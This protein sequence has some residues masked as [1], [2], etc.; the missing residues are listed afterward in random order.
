MRYAVKLDSTDGKYLS[1]SYSDDGVDCYSWDDGVECATLMSLK[2]ASRI[3]IAVNQLSFSTEIVAV[4]QVT[5][6]AEVEV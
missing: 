5:K 1:L 6:W 3:L 4:E 2:K